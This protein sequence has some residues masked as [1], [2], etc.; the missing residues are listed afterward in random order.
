MPP[1]LVWLFSLFPTPA[2]GIILTGKKGL[3][4]PATDELEPEASRTDV[5][6]SRSWQPLQ[7]FESPVQRA[8]PSKCGV[9]AVLAQRVG[10]YQEWIRSLEASMRRLIDAV[11]SDPKRPWKDKTRRQFVIDAN[12]I[13][14]A[15]LLTYGVEAALA[16]LVKQGYSPGGEYRYA[17]E[18]L[19]R[20]A[21]ERR[22]ERMAKPR[23]EGR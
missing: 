21:L 6:R 19:Y 3:D 22:A 9:P 15:M 1:F 8:M 12:A 20:K 14:E 18:P 11:A 23:K 16:A 5:A 2:P 4:Q 13:F 10:Q 17:A 7:E